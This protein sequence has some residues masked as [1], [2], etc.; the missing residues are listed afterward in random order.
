MKMQLFFWVGVVVL[1]SFGI[2]ME[3]YMRGA[4]A[5]I[6]YRV[7]DDEGESVP[8]AVAHVWFRSDHPKLDIKEEISKWNKNI[9]IY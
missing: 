5:K 8:K 9:F 7:V 6:V 2:D 1:P 4:K 3:T